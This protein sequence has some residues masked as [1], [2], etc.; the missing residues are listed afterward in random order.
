MNIELSLGNILEK[1]TIRNRTTNLAIGCGVFVILMVLGAYVRIPLFFTPVPI[2]LQTFF[3]LLAGAMLGRKW[4]AL[5]QLTYLFLGLSGLPVFQGYGAGAAHIFGPTGG[6]LIGFV[7]ASYV[8]GYLL[9]QRKDAGI[10]RILASMAVGLVVIYAFG[11]T[12]LKL[13]LGTDL[14]TAFILG[15]YPFLPG[16]VVKLIAASSLYMSLQY[17]QRR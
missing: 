2:T 1:T 13:L 11:I 16:A 7:F 6:Y 8:V 15:L 3:V 5:S 10:F 4:G 17:G 9:Q 12:W 14:S